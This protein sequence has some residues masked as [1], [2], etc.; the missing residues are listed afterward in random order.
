MLDI[1]FIRENAETVKNAC[2]NKNVDI[3][4]ERVLALDRGKRQMMTEME[5][6]KAEQNKISRG[7]KDNTAIFAQAK[8]IKAKIKEMEPELE[9]VDSELR[10]MLLQLPNIPL[11][12]VPVGKDDSQNV[13]LRKVGRPATQLFNTPKDY[14][15][16]GE[17]L[18]LIDTERAGKV[19]GSR[20][21]Y[22]KRQLPVLEFALVKLVMDIAQKEGFIPVIPPVMLKDQMARGTGYFEATDEKEAYFLAEDKMY[23]VGTSEQSIVSMYADEVLAEKD[24]PIRYVGFST[25]FRREA[26]S[27]GKDTKGILRVHQFDKLEMV[28][29]SK[30]EQ[31]PDEHKLL[32]SIE[33]KLMKALKL[34]YQVINICTGDL[35]R[36]AAAKFDIEA[37]LPSEKRYRET[38]STSNCTD[39]QAR[40][41][42]IRYKDKTGKVSFVHTLNGTAFAIGR[43]LIMI[44]ENYQQKDG[45]IKVPKVLKKYCGFKVIK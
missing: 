20:F 7:G 38:H 32:L 19:S 34:P 12:G 25:C 26:G 14:M 22:I 36:P 21:G 8:E 43:I 23:L 39:F 5:M 1:N 6:L 45:S 44:M 16:L 11:D 15:E 17:N 30:P 41:L 29:F 27:Y 24:L 10:I 37:W 3:D 2:K 33:E 4:V 9:K 31:S 42:N 18:D 40:R 35:G 28:I 13:V